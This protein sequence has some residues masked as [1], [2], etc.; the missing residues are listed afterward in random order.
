MT[1][2][3]LYPHQV[4]SLD[5]LK[6]SILAG[7]KRPMLALPT[8][9]GKTVV[10]AAIVAGARSKGKRVCFVVPS[11][12]LVD[13]TF[14]RFVANGIDA[15]SMGVIQA[16]HPWRRP[17]APIQ[18]ATA[19]TLARRDRPDVDIVIIDEAHVRHQ[20]IIDWMAEA[21]STLFIG[22]SATPWSKGLGKSFDHLIRPTSIAE[23]IEQGFL[24]PFKVFAP[25]KPDLSGVKTVA[26]DYHEGQLDEVMS[27]SVLVADVVS[28]WLEKGR[29]LPTLCFAVGRNHAKVLTQQFA[30]A[31]VRCAYVDAGTSR[32]ERVAI[33][34]ALNAGDI[35]VV[36]NIGCL[37]TG[38]DWDVRC[39]ILARPTKSEM[40]FTQIIGRALRTAA[41]KDHAL[42][43]DHSDTH[44]RLGFVTDID[45]DELHD[46]SPK[47]DAKQSRSKDATPV[48]KC[49][50]TC[51]AMM[52]AKSPTCL[53]CGSELPRPI[54][55]K[56][57]DG[58]LREITGKAKGKA[59][60]G[61]VKRLLQEQGKAAVYGQ[62]KMIAI[63]RG[64]RDGWIAH[65]YRDVF[66]VWPRG[67][68]RTQALEPTPQLLAWVRSRDIAWAK[69]RHTADGAHA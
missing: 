65:K 2:A 45:H 37:T 61:S 58:E 51:T 3:N 43:L 40:L 32:D 54:G 9:A 55:I 52:P 27:G 10:A 63:R 21:T 15:A 56:V 49:C 5:L 67:L 53:S 47:S 46:G 12:S 50:P 16:D 69:T 30:A 68:D 25:S 62:L 48:P 35:E 39:L 13:Q 64:K 19:Q 14:D 57:E 22:L 38:V 8:G 7:S 24:A 44:Q 6:Q 29:G 33:G 41:G 34:E 31:G 42:I 1:L 66:D 28:T 18:I 11:I 26:G 60:K 36:V 59:E 4:R 23:L 17:H 20:A